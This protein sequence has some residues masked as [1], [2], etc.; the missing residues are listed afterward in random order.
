MESQTAQQKQEKTAQPQ[1]PPNENPAE[2][3]EAHKLAYQKTITKNNQT[4]PNRNA[5]SIKHKK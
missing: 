3:M 5:Q 1:T 2:P 4:P